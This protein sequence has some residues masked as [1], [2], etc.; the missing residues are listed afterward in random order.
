MKSPHSRSLALLLAGLV[1]VAVVMRAPIT[2]VGPVLPRI[3]DEL[4]LT[5]TA[6]GLLTA[7]PLLAFAGASAVVPSVSH[8]W[9]ARPTLLGAL[10]L[11]VVGAGLR[12]LPGSGGAAVAALFAGTALVGV[13]IAVANVLLPAV[14][15][16]EFPARVTAMTG[17]YVVLMGLTGAIS[18]GTAVPLADAAPGGW[19]TALAVWALPALVALAVWA[20]LLRRGQPQEQAV[21]APRA[22]M[23]WRSGLAW[24]VSAFMGLQS[25]GFYVAL[26]W[27]P[28]ALRDIAGLDAAAA[29]WQLFLMQAAGIAAS[30]ALPLL[31]RSHHHDAAAAAVASVLTAVGFAG[32]VLVPAA[33]TLWSVV[34]G[35]GMGATVVLALSFLSARAVNASQSAALSGMAQAVGYLF[36]AA[37]P[38]L[39]GALHGATGGWAVPLGVLAVVTFAQAGVGWA[40]GRPRTLQEA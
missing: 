38:V 28:T 18:S 23:P 36:A 17:G 13:S 15:R 19:R 27:L 3:T 29:G 34:L 30:A 4:G 9:G 24:H 10:V 20:V 21:E 11:M 1:L 22:R 39:V 35:L 31:L 12:W 40:A 37:G 8:R 14:L 16:L 32:L 7:L 33:A 25:V 26:A 6:A 5:S 2:G